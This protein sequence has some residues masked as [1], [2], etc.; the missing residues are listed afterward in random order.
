MT[1]TLSLLLLANPRHRA[2]NIVPLQLDTAVFTHS[3]GVPLLS[4]LP[5][6]LLS[7]PYDMGNSTSS[8]SA[9]LEDNFS[10]EGMGMPYAGDNPKLVIAIDIGATHSGV[11]AA[12]LQ[13]S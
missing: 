6:P 3:N 13:P 5:L 2:I 4:S 7:S 8:A 9:F 10:D 11:V 12:L 1:V